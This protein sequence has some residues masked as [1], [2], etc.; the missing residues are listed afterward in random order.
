M[1]SSCVLCCSKVEVYE[2]DY[3]VWMGGWLL[4]CVW[5]GVEKI[6]WCTFGFENKRFV[7]WRRKTCSDMNVMHE[8]INMITS[9]WKVRKKGDSRREELGANKK[10]VIFV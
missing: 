6:G 4:P 3:R 7:G 8:D 5:I 10:L 2:G 1:N 9:N